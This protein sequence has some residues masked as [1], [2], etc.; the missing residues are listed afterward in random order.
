V[1]RGRATYQRVLTWIVNKVSRTILKAGFVVVAFLTTGR[2][3]ISALGMVLLVFM[4]DFVK[5]ALATD[6]VHPSQKPETWKIGPLVRVAIVLGLLM[7]VEALGL[8]VIGWYHFALAGAQGRLQTFTFQTLLF[9]ALFSIVS[10]RERRA[11][12]KSRP[13]GLLAAGLVADAI[14][15][16]VV[17]LC[18]LAELQPLPPEQS[19]FVFGYAAL[20]T[21]GLNDAVKAFLMTGALRATGS[22]S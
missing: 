1:K 2:F 22:Q 14:L 4:T 18:G 11:F 13:S 6:R 3:V 10:L 20:C 15:G 21:L 12:W 19:A 7:L 16:T 5:V 9:F 8:L 17:G